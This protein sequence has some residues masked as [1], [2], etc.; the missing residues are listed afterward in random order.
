MRILR[1][2]KDRFHAWDT[3]T[4]DFDIKKV[5]PIGRGKVLCATAF[6]GP[7]IDFGN[8]PSKLDIID[9]TIYW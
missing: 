8:G 7:E 5:G 4:Y 6:C 3:E 1:K 9:R 2:L